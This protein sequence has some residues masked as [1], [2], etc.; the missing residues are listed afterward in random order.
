MAK[1]TISNRRKK[2]LKSTRNMRHKLKLKKDVP[3]TECSA[4]ERL[5]DEKFIAQAI[6]EC[7]KNN[8]PQGVVEIIETH[9]EVV[10]K[11]KAAQATDLSRATMYHALKSKN[12]TIKTL[13]KMINCFSNTEYINDD[14]CLIS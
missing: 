9:L 11:V 6:W 2:S 8:D 4:T 5:L 13:A 7:L 12:P 14:C 3:V 1:T 10:N